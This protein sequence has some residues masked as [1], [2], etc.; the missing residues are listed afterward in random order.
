[1]KEGCIGQVLWLS[2][3]LN[4]SPLNFEYTDFYTDHNIVPQD[5][6]EVDIDENYQSLTDFQKAIARIKRT[7]EKSKLDPKLEQ[8]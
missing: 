6:I 3:S 1:M 8:K 2:L 5:T 7:Q 4:K